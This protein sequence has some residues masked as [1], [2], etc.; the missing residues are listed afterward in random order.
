MRHGFVS[1][2]VR[3]LALVIVMTLVGTVAIAI[4][5]PAVAGNY[6]AELVLGQNDF[7]HAMKN[8]G[9]RSAL[10]NPNGVGVD[11][12]ISPNRIYVADTGNN[13]ILG[14]AN[15][16][17]LTSGAPADLVLGQNDFNSGYKNG[18]TMN[19]D[20]SGVGPDSLAQPEAVAVDASG[21]VY[22]ADTEN[23][24]ACYI[25]RPS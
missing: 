11:K 18:G 22:V 13:R 8:L 19:G 23:N 4:G 1:G 3:L 15:E 9:G 25:R 12:S 21:N 20:A 5:F 2:R 6:A 10:K 24:R 7:T 17:S 14:W 16:K